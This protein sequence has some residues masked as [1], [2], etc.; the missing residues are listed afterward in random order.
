MKIDKKD[1]KTLIAPIIATLFIFLNIVFGV[2]IPA[3][4]QSEVV[5]G[6]TNT[7]LVGV[8]LYGIWHNHNKEEKKE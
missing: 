8:V 4:V 6:V 7:V 2:E 3:D 5:L 1:L